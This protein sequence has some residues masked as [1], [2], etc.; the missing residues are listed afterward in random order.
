MVRSDKVPSQSLLTAASRCTC[1]Q[2]EGRAWLEAG[3]GLNQSQLSSLLLGVSKELSVRVASSHASSLSCSGP[4]HLE[5][6]LSV[7][8]R[9]PALHSLLSV[10]G[11]SR[12]IR[13]VNSCKSK[14]ECCASCK[15]I[16]Y[17]KRKHL[18]WRPPRRH[19]IRGCSS[20]AGIWPNSIMVAWR[21]ITAEA[22]LPAAADMLKN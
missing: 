22:E 16:I 12:P 1:K 15:G 8:V 21:W 13:L 4:R 18:M 5:A 11:P 19:L 6:Q 17:C 20:S 9:I 3:Q 7:S 2:V 14:H 10:L